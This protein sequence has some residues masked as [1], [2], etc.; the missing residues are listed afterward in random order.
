MLNLRLK[1][2]VFVVSAET[3]K[4]WRDLVSSLKK[5]GLKLDYDY[6]INI[7]INDGIYHYG[8]II[9][10]KRKGKP[11]TTSLSFLVFDKNRDAWG[12]AK[13]SRLLKTNS[14]F[15]IQH[16]IYKIK[17]SDEVLRIIIRTKRNF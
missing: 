15:L 8:A 12:K 5:N 1:K 11:E 17:E 7:L 10:K 6:L 16:L 2:I 4:K 9:R 3:G 13:R 14:D